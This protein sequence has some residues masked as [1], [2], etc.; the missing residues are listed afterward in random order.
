MRKLFLLATLLLAGI[1]TTPVTAAPLAKFNGHTA[2]S[3]TYTRVNAPADWLS[4]SWKEMQ[5]Y[6]PPDA[7]V[8]VSDKV[9]EVEIP[10]ADESIR[11]RFR[12]SPVYKGVRVSSAGA[13]QITHSSGNVIARNVPTYYFSTTS[14]S[15]RP[16]ESRSR[17]VSASGSGLGAWRNRPAYFARQ[18]DDTTTAVLLTVAT[19]QD[20]ETALLHM[21]AFGSTKAFGLRGNDAW[22]VANTIDFSDGLKP[23]CRYPDGR[24]CVVNAKPPKAFPQHVREVLSL[25]AVP[26]LKV[27][28]AKKAV[29]RPQA[30]STAFMESF[31]PNYWNVVGGL[32]EPGTYTGTGTGCTVKLTDKSFKNTALVGVPSG[33]SG[34]MQTVVE[35]RV[36]DYA[37]STCALARTTS[38]TGD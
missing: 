31:I 23:S 36:G 16:T 6:L 25:P 21:N 19:R 30:S 28:T 24:A 15:D 33:T 32:L 4:Y 26:V 9:L 35:L 22:L 17:T 20:G 37:S 7:Q 27:D 11:V 29:V 14:R 18:A 10:T 3:N 34:T 12:T 5:V 2:W 1:S 38:A 8:H 13:L